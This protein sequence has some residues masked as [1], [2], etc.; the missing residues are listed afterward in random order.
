MTTQRPPHRNPYP[1]LRSFEPDESALFFGREAETDELRTRLRHT[2]F[3]AV[4]GGSGSGKSSL[5][6]SGLVP[7]LHAGFMSGVG[8]GWRVA[9]TR[10]GE[11]PIGRLA[12]ALDDPAVLGPADSRADTRRT[13]LEAMLRDSS[14]G[15]AD[16][17][18]QATLPAGEKL[19]LVVDQFEELYRFR[20]S[21]TAAGAADDAAAFVRLLLEAGRTSNLYVVLTMRSEFIGECML[22]DGLPEA[23]NTGQYLIPR[24]GRD[25]LRRAISGPAEVAG[26]SVAPRLVTRLLNEVGGE[27]DRLPVLQHA[28]MRT[29]DRWAHDP[30]A[31]PA[32]DLP[33]YEAI[34]TLKQALSMHADEAWAELKTTRERAIAERLFKTLTE[35]TEGGRGL[36][37]PTAMAALAAICDASVDELQRVIEPFRAPGRGFLQPP[38]GVALAPTVIVDI[39]HESLMRLWQRL[40]QWVQQEAR[41]TD[42]YRRLAT[43]AARHAAGEGGLWRPPELTLGLRWREDNKPSAAWAGD[44]DGF[45]QAMSFLDRSQRA[46]RQRLGAGVAAGVLAVVLAVGWFA[47]EVRRQ[48]VLVDVQQAEAERQRREA[49]AQR[50][51]AQRLQAEVTRLSTERDAAVQEQAAQSVE[52]QALR[53]RNAALRQAVAGL[54]AQR[55]RVEAAVAALRSDNQRLVDSIAAAAAETLRLNAEADRLKTEGR[56]IQSEILEVQ[57]VRSTLLPVP[58]LLEERVAALNQQLQALDLQLATLQASWRETQP[59]V[60]DQPA[61][62][63]VASAGVNAPA[64]SMLTV[65]PALPAIPGDTVARDNLRSEIDQLA[66]ELAALADERAR[67][68]DE[69]AWL[70]KEN[71]LLERQRNLLQQETVRLRRER[72]DL[73]LRQNALQQA[74]AQ[75][76]AQRN[77]A[78]SEVASMQDVIARALATMQ[79]ER[80]LEREITDKVGDATWRVARQTLEVGERKAVA[81]ELAGR[82]RGPV[83]RLLQSALRR[84]TPADLAPLLALTARRW[85]PYDT[86]DVAQ[87][88]VYNT[89]WQLLRRADEP[90]ARALLTATEAAGGKAGTT[91]TAALAQAL[92]ARGARPITEAEWRRYMPEGACY[93]PAVAQACRP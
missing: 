4:V 91:T 47:A 23:I 90:A 63:M 38:A 62:S 83:D 43:A 87:P 60:L 66:R 81:A 11:D 29:W 61:A 64:A 9:I 25:A 6:R 71:A 67:L 14:L 41:A 74:L 21:R 2:R 70:G 76:L 42:I 33:Q 13:V 78:E 22:F 19:L 31:G 59:C 54:Q 45:A 68:R 73:Q 39:S 49:D 30:D 8:S 52:V 12:A 79:A 92:C 80:R 51:E 44:V 69:A 84:E 24:M 40:L 82:L 58:E 93:T 16:A 27:L 15:L 75:T 89:L 53:T 20:R 34:G 5:V 18:R 65:R 77:A 10:P 46:Q 36:R 7:T 1:G 88:A 48:R 86:D 57:R 32:L 3:L 37:R 26:A 72:A 85:A 56:R 35:T 28:L 17:V 55:S 50:A